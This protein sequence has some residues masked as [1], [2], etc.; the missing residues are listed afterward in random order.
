[1]IGDLG[2]GFIEHVER[3][4]N[5]WIEKLK[6]IDAATVTDAQKRTGTMDPFIKPLAYG[7]KVLGT[8][9][10][11]D[12]P[13]GDN[14][15]L[16]KAM[17]LAKPG[18]VLVVHTNKNYSK[19]IWGELMTR[20]AAELQISG[21]VVDGLIR[22]GRFNR[23]TD[24]PIFC[25]GTAP[26]SVE[27]N[28]PGFV[29]GEITCGGVVVKPGDIVVGDDDG[30]VVVNKEHLSKVIENIEKLEE[31]E[32]ARKKEILGGKALPSWLNSKLN[33]AGLK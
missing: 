11:V 14:L 15:M 16:Y 25:R 30:V 4:D 20:S 17:Q 26:V 27:K 29:N 22:D 32:T 19:A 18:D 9:I 33:N 23:E 21:L 1:V 7:K 31:R 10:T 13:M 8:A 6:N 24:F 2:F 5:K 3:A 12:L 28:G